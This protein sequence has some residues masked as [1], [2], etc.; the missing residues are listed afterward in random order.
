[1]MKWVRGFWTQRFAEGQRFAEIFLGDDEVGERILDTEIRR[2]AEI[3][4]DFF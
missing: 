4:R 2:G 1:M 3:H